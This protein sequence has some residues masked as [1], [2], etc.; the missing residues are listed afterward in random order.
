LGFLVMKRPWSWQLLKRKRI[1]LE[2][3]Y[4]FRGLVYYHHGGYHG[5]IQADMVL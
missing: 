2:L 4:S 5:S 3:A 1:N